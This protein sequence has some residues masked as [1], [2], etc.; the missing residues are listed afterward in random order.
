[1]DNWPR[2]TDSD[3]CFEFF[4]TGVNPRPPPFLEIICHF[5]SKMTPPPSHLEK[6]K[7]SS[8]SVGLAFPY[9]DLGS[10][11]TADNLVCS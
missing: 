10:N 1:M 11:F 4:Q 7:K 3:E 8:E 2:P 9:L 6:L 5:F